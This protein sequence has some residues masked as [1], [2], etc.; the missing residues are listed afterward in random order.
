[1]SGL[2]DLMMSLAK[3]A[4]DKDNKKLKNTISEV[5]KMSETEDDDIDIKDYLYNL[6]TPKGKT[7]DIK[8]K[9]IWY[10]DKVDGQYIIRNK[11]GTSSWAVYKYREIIFKIKMIEINDYLFLVTENILNSINV[12]KELEEAIKE[13]IRPTNGGLFDYKF[14]LNYENSKEML[15]ELVHTANGKRNNILES[16]TTNS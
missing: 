2:E 9:K 1:M 4:Q 10:T 5:R 8:I 14:N 16:M 15:T 11:N 12:D 7:Y 3:E 6:F 13:N